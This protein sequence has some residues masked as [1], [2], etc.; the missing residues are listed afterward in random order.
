[1]LVEKVS[2]FLLSLFTAMLLKSAALRAINI[3][4]IHSLGFSII[5]EVCS[6]VYNKV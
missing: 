2:I 6:R 4:V 1:M 5:E 3:K